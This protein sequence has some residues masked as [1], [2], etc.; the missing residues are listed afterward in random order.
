M[1][2]K[3]ISTVL[4]ALLILTT[5]VYAADSFGTTLRANAQAKRED[6]VT[7]TFGLKD[8][9]I[10]SGEKGIC[11]Y[12]TTLEFSP[13]VFEYVSSKGT[14]KWEDPLYQEG[15]MVAETKSTQV[16]TTPQDVATITLKVKDN[17]PLGETTIKLTKFIGTTM[18]P[19]VEAKD[20]ETKVTILAKDD[21]NGNGGNNNDGNNNQNNVNNNNIV[22]EPTNNG[23][24][25]TVNNI[26][27]TP[28]TNNTNTNTQKPIT[29]TD[30]SKKDGK[31]PQTGSNN[32][33]M[34][35]L[36][37]TCTVLAIVFLVKTIKT[38]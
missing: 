2:N 36:I 38:K 4:V 1:K 29:S 28:N 35:T 22:N 24:T 31:L 26:V 19:D 18:G 10:E 9:A 27:V 11:A 12:T 25:N 6:T 30:N 21:G 17:A 33:A 14:D 3:V 5:R 20:I 23:N 37:G 16:E 15:T 7:V 8:I 34:I 13:D 32:I